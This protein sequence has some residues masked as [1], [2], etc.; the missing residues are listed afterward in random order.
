MQVLC[1]FNKFNPIETF[2]SGTSNFAGVLTEYKVGEVVRADFY[3]TNMAKEDSNGLF[4]FRCLEGAY[5][6][7]LLGL[8]TYSGDYFEWHY[9]GKLKEVG[10]LVNGKREGKFEDFYENGK[11][12]TVSY[13]TTN[14]LNGDY[15][16]W[17]EN[18]NK[19]ERGFYVNDI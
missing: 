17:F 9:N 10:Q 14:K 19:S 18:G 13:Y 8:A 4:Y 3:D 16:E 11:K 2:E 7:G 1:V 15:F 6:Y 5:F 12:F